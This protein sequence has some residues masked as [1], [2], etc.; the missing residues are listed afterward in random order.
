MDQRRA[1]ICSTKS[2]PVRE[3]SPQLNHMIKYQQASNNEKTNMVFMTMVDV[4]RQ[5]FTDQTGHF[6]VTSNRGHNYIVIFYAVDPNYIKSYPVKSRHRSELI[7]A[8]TEVYQ[9]LRVRGYRPQLHKLDN[10]TSKDVE[11]FIAEN[12]TKFQYTPPDIHRT[13]PAERAIHTWK[14]RL[15]AIQAGTPSTYRLSNWCKDLKQT[16]ITL[17]MLRPCT[18]NP[19]LS[20]HKAMEV[21][22]S[23]NRTPMAPIRAEVMIHI[24]PN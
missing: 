3:A 23:F 18:T 9:F 21:M 16:D 19:L 13:N 20:T 12:N 15:V 4:D 1:N 2:S 8:Y 7:Q 22:F 14:N 10:K 6:T 17:N 24:K 11:A 5:L